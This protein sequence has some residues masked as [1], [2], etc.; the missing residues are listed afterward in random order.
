MLLFDKDQNMHV[1]RKGSL[2]FK[3]NSKSFYI[4]FD[5]LHSF[6][7]Q[8]HLVHNLKGT[9]QIF[10]FNFSEKTMKFEKAFNTKS[11]LVRILLQ[12]DQLE[13]D[14]GVATLLMPLSTMKNDFFKNIQSLCETYQRMVP[15]NNEEIEQAHSLA[16]GLLEDLVMALK[17]SIPA[18]E[19][20]TS[21]TSS[22]EIASCMN[23]LLQ[24]FAI[25]LAQFEQHSRVELRESHDLSQ[26]IGM[27]L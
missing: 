23:E 21:Q 11:Y 5:D 1:A 2:R 26:K 18:L 3:H 7:G 15:K 14:L 8:L 25:N 6:N 4:S 20:M 12:E 13:L 22:E 27:G 10:A 9:F 24:K 17:D 16:K 19:K